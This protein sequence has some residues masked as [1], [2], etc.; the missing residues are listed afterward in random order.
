MC[1]ANPVADTKL[2]FLFC[3]VLRA[4]GLFNSKST[5]CALHLASSTL[6]R[7]ATR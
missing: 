7:Q 6:Q 3:G 5:V 2:V 4:L 1:Q